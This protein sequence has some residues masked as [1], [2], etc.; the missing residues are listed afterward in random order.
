MTS[1]IVGVF[2]LVICST[3]NLLLRFR[4]RKTNLRTEQHWRSLLKQTLSLAVSLFFTYL[5]LM[6]CILN[7]N[8]IKLNLDLIYITVVITGVDVIFLLITIAHYYPD[9]FS[10]YKARRSR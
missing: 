4:T 7:H 2:N 1:A 9:R 10:L 3:V 8:V 6:F 5:T